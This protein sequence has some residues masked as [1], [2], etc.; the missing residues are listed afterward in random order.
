M[1]RG[2][3]GVADLRRVRHVEA[4]CTT[5]VSLHFGNGGATARSGSNRIRAFD[6]ARWCYLACDRLCLPVGG[7]CMAGRMASAECWQIA[8]ARES[9]ED[10]IMYIYCIGGPAGRGTSSRRRESRA[11]GEE[12]TCDAQDVDILQR[13]VPPCTS[14]AEMGALRRATYLPTHCLDFMNCL[15]RP[16]RGFHDVQGIRGCQRSMRHV[17]QLGQ[18][19]GCPGRRQS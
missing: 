12:T 4:P 5:R 7:A 13:E 3:R 6:A 17:N 9:V 10:R 16:I 11:A 15:Y 14:D 2:Q 1:A 8:P 18:M 19:F